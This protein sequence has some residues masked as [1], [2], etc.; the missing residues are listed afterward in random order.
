MH[1]LFGDFFSFL[2]LKV[3]C[4]R[5]VIFT[6]CRMKKNNSSVTL[7]QTLGDTSFFFQNY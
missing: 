5:Q 1:E 3:A 6:L 7:I 4:T 2:D